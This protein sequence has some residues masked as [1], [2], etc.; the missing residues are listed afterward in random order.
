MMEVIAHKTS[1]K[2]SAAWREYDKEGMTLYGE[3]SP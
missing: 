3:N 1:M 2:R